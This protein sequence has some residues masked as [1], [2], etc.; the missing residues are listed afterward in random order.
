MLK[1]KLC[2]SFLFLSIFLISSFYPPSAHSVILPW[3]HS[4]NIRVFCLLSHR[5]ALL[6]LR[7]S[8]MPFYVCF[9]SL[10]TF[11]PCLTHSEDTIS[12]AALIYTIY[13]QTHVFVLIYS[14]VWVQFFSVFYCVVLF[15]WVPFCSLPQATVE[16]IMKEKMPKKGGRWWFSWRGRNSG[17]KS[18]NL[19]NLL[20]LFNLS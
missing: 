12:C 14:L 9:F 4:F 20:T 7:T 19:L 10:F 5:G 1:V 16:K 6:Q 18:V 15:V 17:N 3:L 13:L 11:S 8:D 2:L